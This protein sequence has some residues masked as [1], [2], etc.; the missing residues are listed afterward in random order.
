[1]AN[2]SKIFTVLKRKRFASNEPLCD[3]SFD[4]DQAANDCNLLTGLFKIDTILKVLNFEI[5]LKNK[6]F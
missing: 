5:Y 1:M 4:L 3:Y 2:H 6:V